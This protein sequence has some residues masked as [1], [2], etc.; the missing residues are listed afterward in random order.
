MVKNSD[1]T[2]FISHVV[3]L[4]VVSGEVADVNASESIN[5]ASNPVLSETTRFVDLRLLIFNTADKL[6]S[7]CA[8]VTRAEGLMGSLNWIALAMVLRKLQRTE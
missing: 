8:S 3:G 2:S 7:V 4:E 6:I 1:S 5:F